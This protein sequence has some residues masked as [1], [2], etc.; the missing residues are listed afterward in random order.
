MAETRDLIAR[1]ETAAIELRARVLTALA[2]RRTLAE[3]LDRRTN[4]YVSD[5]ASAIA[6]RA[7][8]RARTEERLRRLQDYST[9]FSRLD[10]A[11]AQQS[12]LD[13]QLAAI[14]EQLAR[15]MARGAEVEA[16]IAALEQNFAN[17][18]ERLDIPR[19]ADPPTATIDRQTFLPRVDGR[20]FETASQGMKV[21][22]NV[23][24]ALAHQLTAIQE[25]LALPNWLLI[26]ALSSNLGH[27]GYDEAVRERLY[28]YL[29]DV[30][31]EHRDRL[32]IVV[33]DNDVPAVAA[34]FVRLQ[35][36]RDDMLVPMP[37]A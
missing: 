28:E 2:R 22:I 1:H 15:E 3:E 32:Q 35:L 8:D 14:E 33:A 9:L 4:A 12:E 20:S 13:T 5:T 29:V 37:S 11:Q 23:A 18:L 34:D 7:S 30:S 36:G 17:I 16:R 19:F 24:H 10:A 26:D 6:Q 21:L 27:G 25:N 31:A